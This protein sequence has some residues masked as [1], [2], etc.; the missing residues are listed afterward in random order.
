MKLVLTTAELRI[1]RRA[2]DGTDPQKLAQSEGVATKEINRKLNEV[3]KKL[4]A[5]DPVEAI[6]KLAKADF[7][8]KD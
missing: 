4:H 3:C 2:A 6:Q 8:V 1:L 5:H 7:T